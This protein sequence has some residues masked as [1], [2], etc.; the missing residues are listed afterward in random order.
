M[1]DYRSVVF[2]FMFFWSS[3]HQLKTWPLFFVGSD[4]RLAPF[5]CTAHHRRVSGS[6]CRVGPVSSPLKMGGIKHQPHRNIELRIKSPPKQ[7][8]LS[9][10]KI[11][12]PVFWDKFGS[13]YLGDHDISIKKLNQYHI[14]ILFSSQCFFVTPPFLPTLIPTPNKSSKS[15]VRPRGLPLCFRRS[16]YI[17]DPSWGNRKWV[18]AVKGTRESEGFLGISGGFRWF[19]KV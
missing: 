19:E 5:P 12:C 10:E 1:L 4:A 6:A 16:G 15:P 2:V 3:H 17:T 13:H 14:S 9:F 18:G 7:D 8:P 11:I